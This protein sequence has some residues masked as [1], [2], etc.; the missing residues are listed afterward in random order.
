MVEPGILGR[1][2]PEGEAERRV[3]QRADD[4]AGVLPRLER[5]AGGERGLGRLALALETE[6]K[7]LHAAEEPGDAF[8]EP[9]HG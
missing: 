3:R 2:G 7:D 8:D 9:G 1:I 6:G 5:L 4:G